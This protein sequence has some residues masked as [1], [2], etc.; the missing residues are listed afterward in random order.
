MSTV[1]PITDLNTFADKTMDTPPVL[2]GE[3]VLR[4]SKNDI[5]AIKTHLAAHAVGINDNQAQITANLGANVQAAHTTSTLVLTDAMNNHHTPLDATGTAIA[6]SVP[7]TLTVGVGASYS[8]LNIG[9]PITIVPTGALGFAM[10]F[11]G[12]SVID[13]VGDIITV[14]MESATQCRVTIAPRDSVVV[15]V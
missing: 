7:S 5:N 10:N 2:A 12:K 13:T 6:I 4:F 11:T 15:V 9:N 1:P 3:E 14:L 8:V